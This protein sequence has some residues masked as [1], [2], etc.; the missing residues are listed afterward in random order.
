MDTI[1]SNESISKYLVF[2][3]SSSSCTDTFS[4]IVLLGSNTTNF[5]STNDLFISYP[6]IEY[7]RFEV[8]YSFAAES[9]SSALNFQINQSPENGSCSINPYN[10]TTST[11]FTISCSDWA[12]QDGI[13][14]YSI[15]SMFLFLKLAFS[16]SENSFV[17]VWT[18]DRRQ[19]SMIAFSPLSNIDLRLPAGTDNSSRIHLIVYIRDRL[20]C[21]TKYNLTSV[22]VV[23]DTEGINNLINTFQASSTSAINSNP[24]IQIFTSGNQNA[25]TQAVA[26]LSKVFNQM[27]NKNLDQAISS[28]SYPIVDDFYKFH[29]SS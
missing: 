16:Q 20:D 15:Y 7:W 19:L 23:P 18:T 3:Y 27:N 14:D 29:S 21:T 24:I 26:S 28:K 13:K 22:I 1:Q 9:S 5:T 2:W 4:S 8:T 12:D 25:I 6:L 17:T 11:L 10:G